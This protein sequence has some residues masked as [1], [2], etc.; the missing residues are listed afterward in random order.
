MRLK[1]IK[2]CLAYYLMYTCTFEVHEY[3]KSQDFEKVTYR[4][5]GKFEDQQRISR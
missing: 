2:V 3:G 5:T 4:S 1:R